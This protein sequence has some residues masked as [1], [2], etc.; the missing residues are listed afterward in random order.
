MKKTK[1]SW[2]YCLMAVLSLSFVLTSC[3]K[4]D[5]DDEINKA[6]LIGVWKVVGSVEYLNGEKDGEYGEA[7]AYIELKSDGTSVIV[8]KDEFGS[9]SSVSPWKLDGN[10]I[11]RT[12]IDG[13]YVATIK[14]LNSTTLVFS[15]EYK[16]EDGLWTIET[17]FKKVSSLPD[18]GKES[19]KE[20]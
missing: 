1:F 14:T 12:D 5:D 15:E 3:D 8:E 16:D 6:D 10:K 13:D 7:E 4:D 9:S 2:L 19:L 17:K 11:V 18:W 20:L